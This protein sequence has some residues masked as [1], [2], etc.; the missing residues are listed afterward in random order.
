MN[1]CY[2]KITQNLP[3]TLGEG[4]GCSFQILAVHG[5]LLYIYV[6][7]VFPNIS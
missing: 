4:K 5:E 6:T 7:A 2:S 3:N 1:E